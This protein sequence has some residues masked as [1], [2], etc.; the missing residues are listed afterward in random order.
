MTGYTDR[1]QEAMA[2]GYRVLPKPT[3]PERLLE[4]LSQEL[5]GARA[6]A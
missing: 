6:T 4:A 3:P 2:L 5:A 1:L